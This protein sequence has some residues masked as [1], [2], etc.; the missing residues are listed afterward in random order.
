MKIYL[1]LKT[2]SFV[3][4]FKFWSV[5]ALT[6]SFLADMLIKNSHWDAQTS[7]TTRSLEE[8]VSPPSDSSVAMSPPQIVLEIFWI[9]QTMHFIQLRTWWGSFQTWSQ[10]INDLLIEMCWVSHD[11]QRQITIFHQSWVNLG[12]PVHWCRVTL[13]QTEAYRFTWAQVPA[14]LPTTSLG[15][16]RSDRW[17]PVH[18][19]WWFFPPCSLNVWICH[20][21]KSCNMDRA[22]IY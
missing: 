17:P 7:K 12:L 11:L 5:L 16:H 1:C 8:I 4:I 6:Y 2:I 3:H 20:Q 13:Q 22:M 9:S 14:H 10:H 18:T 19:F 15:W 21:F